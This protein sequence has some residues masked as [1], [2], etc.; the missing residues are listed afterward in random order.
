LKEA[1][2]SFN[3]KTVSQDQINTLIMV[4]PKES[5][6]DDLEKEELQPGEIWEKGEQYMLQLCKPSSILN[7]LKVWTFKGKWQEEKEIVDNF[8]KNIM[9]AY[10]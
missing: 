9:H 6:L 8:Y 4:W 2:F 1:I 5:N 10:S 7:R 3:E